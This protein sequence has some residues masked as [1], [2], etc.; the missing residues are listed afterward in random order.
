M[1]EQSI[2]TALQS[3]L[4]SEESDQV[5]ANGDDYYQSLLDDFFLGDKKNFHWIHPFC[6]SPR[7]CSHTNRTANCSYKW[8][9]LVASSMKSCPGAMKEATLCLSRTTLCLLVAKFFQSL[10]D[11]S[12]AKM[13]KEVKDKDNY[14]CQSFGCMDSGKVF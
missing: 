10:N 3:I 11:G 2:S 8:E 9:M 1:I 6:F 14:T 12:K 4:Q 7:S 13:F 5:K